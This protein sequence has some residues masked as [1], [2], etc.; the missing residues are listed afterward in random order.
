[1]T[2]SLET[3]RSGGHPVARGIILLLTAVLT[4]ACSSGLRL[5]PQQYPATSRG[6]V[7]DDY[8]GTQVADPYRWLEQPDSPATQAFIAAENALA[9]PFLDG[10]PALAQFRNRLTRLYS[11]ERFGVPTEAGGQYFF[12]RNDGRQDQAALHVA[13]APGELGRLLID[14]GTLRGDGTVSLTNYEPSPDGRLLAYALSD[15]GS[16]WKTWHVRD[17]ATGADLPD[18]LKD[19]KFTGVSWARDGSGFYYS[20][21][22]GGDDQLQ[23]VIRFHRLGDE[24]QRDREVYAVRDHPTRVPYGRVTQDGRYLV[25]T[26]DEGTTRNGI[27]ALALDGSNAV[28]DVA[29]AYDG[30]YQYLGSRRGTGTELL[31]R[32]NAGAPNGRVLAVDL[33]AAT[34]TRQRIVVPEGDT[35]I[36]FAALVGDRVLLAT[37][38]DASSR[39]VRYDA[40]NG[41]SLGEVALPGLGAIGG[42][43][44]EPDDRESFFSYTD[45]STPTRIYRLDIASGDAALLRTPQF[46][47]DVS[48]FI[49][50]QAFYASRDG[51]RIPLFIVRHRDAKRDGGNPVMLYGYGGFDISMTPAFS[52]ATIAWLEQGGIYAVANLRG[53]GEYGAAWHLAGTR[54]RKQNV[55]DDFIAAAEFLVSEKWTRPGRLVIRGGSNGGLL[56]GAVITQRPELFGAALPDV[57]VHDMLRYHLAS[58]NA[59]QWSDDFGL[60]E[61]AQDFRAQLAYSP[62]HNTGRQQ[63]YPPTLVTT[64][65]QDNRVVPWHSFKFAAALQ[66]AQRCDESGAAARRNTRGSWRRQADV[67]DHRSLR[68]AMGVRRG[69]DRHARPLLR[70]RAAVFGIGGFVAGDGALFGEPGAQVHHL[71]AFAAERPPREVLAPHELALAGGTRTRGALIAPLAGDELE[72]DVAFSLRRSR[73]QAVPAQEAHAA[74]MMAAADFRIDARVGGHADAQQLQRRVAIEVDG[75]GAAAATSLRLR[76][77]WRVS[78]STSATASHSG[79]SSASHSLKACVRLPASWF[80]Q[81]KIIRQVE[82][83]GAAGDGAAMLDGREE[84]RVAQWLHEGAA[85]S[86]Q[87]RAQPRQVVDERA[88]AAAIH[89]G[90]VLEL[91][92]LRQMPFDFLQHLGAHVAAG[93]DGQDV[94][95]AA[96]CRATAPLAGL[97]V[98]VQRLV[99]EEVQAQEG[100]HPLVERL[101]EYQRRRGGGS[102]FGSVATG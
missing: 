48:P 22:P 57:G 86:G 19:M 23:A 82:L 4:G 1:M 32:S 60:S 97:L 96:D 101:F 70:F 63:C 11:Y 7:V 91:R 35:V 93:G 33:G 68:G 24:Q 34:A 92:Q 45:F 16:D 30:V 42:L 65:A 73:G 18:L 44:G 77:F 5:A 80:S 95:E 78:H 27:I 89:P 67:D 69:G 102:G 55:F 99:V 17:V 51:T 28:T 9:R 76:P 79:R 20:A 90:L 40:A 72:G 54:E 46:A 88:Q 53:G 41:R 49:T 8:H 94:D 84:L 21:Y 29:T 38:K 75:E 39:L 64:A 10:L 71:A 83:A 12:L 56:V 36:E 13:A 66:H 85:R 6:D 31:L 2:C 98:V 59:R 58:A 100:A 14:P 25:I 62:L 87:R 81:K 3:R 15:S 74:A 61:N 37:L 43:T 47:A 26:L 52:P 50:E